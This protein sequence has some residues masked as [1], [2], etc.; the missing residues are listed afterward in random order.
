VASVQDG[1]VFFLGQINCA[2]LKGLPSAEKL[3]PSGLLAFFADHDAVNGCTG[4]YEDAFAVYHWSD[5]DRLAPA[6]PPVELQQIFPLCALVFRPIIE[7][8]DPA[9]RF[10]EELDWGD[11]DEWAYDDLR[12][13]IRDHGVPEPF[14]EFTGHSKLLGWP[15]WVQYESEAMTELDKLHG[16]NLLLQLDAFTDGTTYAEWGG[17]GS[18]YF[19]IRDADLAA[20][21]FDRCVFE[22]QGT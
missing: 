21:R 19:M 20:A 9:S 22:M 18:L 11:E 2:E 14:R 13:A 4:D 10:I 3:P 12:E 8:P 1:A 6:S 7:F 5:L 15:D 17:G 16:L